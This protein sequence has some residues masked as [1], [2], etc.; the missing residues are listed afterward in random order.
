MR[1]VEDLLAT[2]VLRILFRRSDLSGFST[3]AVSDGLAGHPKGKC[4]QRSSPMVSV[5]REAQFISHS[6]GRTARRAVTVMGAR[7]PN[8]GIDPTGEAG[9]EMPAPALPAG[10]C[11]P[12]AAR[13]RLREKGPKKER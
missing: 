13:P 7:T 3:P 4:E 10:H 1:P 12:F 9:T 11:S 2:A 8:Y 6:V 5:R